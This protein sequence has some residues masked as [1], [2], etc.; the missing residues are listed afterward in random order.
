M[1][2]I[3]KPTGRSKYIIEYIDETGNRRRK[4][5]TTD[6]RLTERLAARIEEDVAL[7]KG[8]LVDRKA[9]AYRDHEALSLLDHLAD[10]HKDLMAKGK[11]AKHAALSRDRAGKLIALVRGA[12]LDD[13]VPGRKAEAMERAARLLAETLTKARFSELTAERIQAALARLREEGRSAQTANHFRAAIRGFL[14]WCHRRGRIRSVPTD[15]V[16]GFNVEEDLRHPRRSLTDDEL[17]R[18]I[19]YAETA[20]PLWGMPGPLRAMAYRTGAGTGFRVDELRSLTPE[21]F[22]LEGST[23]E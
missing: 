6:K 4:T 22:H 7:R 21:S 11:T 2:T 20:R 12:S 13:L 1:A 19:A 23:G 14:K 5:G 17:A 9:E 15:G 8:G 10:W 3:Y 16:E 18:L